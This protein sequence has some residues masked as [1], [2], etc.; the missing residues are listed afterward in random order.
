MLIHF[1][2]KFLYAPEEILHNYISIKQF[3]IPSEYLQQIE[4]K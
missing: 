3:P 1:N 2:T 4:S